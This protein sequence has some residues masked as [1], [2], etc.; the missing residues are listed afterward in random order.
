[1]P[2]TPD[3]SV[4]DRPAAIRGGRALAL[5][6]TLIL[7]VVA[8]Q[9]N[10]SMITPA[11]PD[12]SAQLGAPMDAVSQVSSLFFLAGA[13]GGVVL[14][15]WSD[16][17]GR[18]RALLIVLAL[19]VLGTVLC[20]FAPN[21]PVLLLGRVL[22]GASSAAF[23]ISYVILAETLPAAVFPTTLGVLTA[24]NGGV[25]G[26]DGWIGGLL[27][28]EFGFRSLFV[29]ILVVAVVAIVCVAFAVP[30][31]GEPSS[32]G[33]MDWWGAAALSAG[34]I[35][36]TY[37][38]STGSA[39]GWFAPLTLAFLAGTVVSFVLFVVIEKRRRT[40]LIAV[41]HL[42]SRQVW[43]VLA[44]TVLT[45]SSVFAVINFTVVILSQDET[46]GFGLNASTS[47][48]LFLA[49]PAI[50][51]LAAAPVSGWLAGR[52]GWIPMLRIGMVLSVLT[53]IV[54]A[55]A[56]QSQW[57]V[58]AM[59]AVL[60]VAYNGLVLTTTNGLG[61]LQSPTEAPAI[62]PSMN[63][64]AFGFGASLGIAIVAP[65][66]ASGGIGGYTTALWISVGISVLALTA[67]LFIVPK[68]D[69]P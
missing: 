57:M 56:P 4:I 23:Q 37:F 8:F 48:L 34:L 30:R 41:H 22:Q 40:P 52:F 21:L 51:G 61:V 27:A 47:A 6:S 29:V 25:G 13:V 65:F 55:I 60:G 1:M 50:I 59:I 66:V 5:V 32:T 68:T 10:S 42:R 36:I 7:T 43:P 28:D 64:T 53:L 3:A 35:C 67:T 11:L 17:I 46:V 62:L 44:T 49:P 20:I 15:R 9:L 18:K 63:S 16:F 54:I 69:R 58:F 45:L 12:I 33:R 26:V 19:I 24:I 14:A 31:D 39:Q 2:T 38:V